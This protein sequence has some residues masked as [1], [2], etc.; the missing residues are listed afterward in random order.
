[1]RRLVTDTLVIAERNLVRLPRAPDLLLA[2]TVQPVMFVLLFVYVF[3]G[4]I[5]TP[6]LRLRR[7]PDPR[8]HRPEHRLR[9][10]RHR[11]RARTRTST[12]A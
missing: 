8:D 11:A 3:G 1:M 5:S 4:A 10:L 6:R 2:F 12:R 7:L 9:R